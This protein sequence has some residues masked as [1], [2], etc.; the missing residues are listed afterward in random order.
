MASYEIMYLGNLCCAQIESVYTTVAFRTI[1]SSYH[2]ATI[3]CV[4]YLYLRPMLNLLSQSSTSC[5]WFEHQAVLQAHHQGDILDCLSARTS[6]TRRPSTSGGRNKPHR[7]SASSASVTVYYT[8]S[9]HP[10]H[11]LKHALWDKNSPKFHSNHRERKNTGLQRKPAWIKC[12]LDPPDPMPTGQRY[13][14]KDLLPPFK[15]RHFR[16]QPSQYQLM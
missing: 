11:A 1:N 13:G 12:L 8:A 16:P 6:S 14:G 7:L 9:A 3:S 10:K 4:L 2:G 5:C 15:S